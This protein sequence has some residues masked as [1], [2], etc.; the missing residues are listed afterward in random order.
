MAP[1]H[2]VYARH[3][4]ETTFKMVM[5]IQMLSV[6]TPTTRKHRGLAISLLGPYIGNQKDPAS[7]CIVVATTHE[8][9]TDVIT[10]DI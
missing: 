7:E 6:K 10:D 5:Y 1:W 4:T 2:I 3:C 9:Y 8:Q